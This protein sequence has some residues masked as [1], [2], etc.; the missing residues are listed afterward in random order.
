MCREQNIEAALPLKWRGWG[1]KFAFMRLIAGQVPLKVIFPLRKAALP[2]FIFVGFS[3]LAVNVISR[4]F[5]R[6]FTPVSSRIA[7]ECDSSH[8]M[9]EEKM[10]GSVDRLLRTVI[11]MRGNTTSSVRYIGKRD[12]KSE[13]HLIEHLMGIV[14]RD[15]IR[16]GSTPIIQ[17]S[18]FSGGKCRNFDDRLPITV[19]R[20]PIVPNCRFQN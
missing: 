1:F 17:Y 7:L 20:Q 16:R 2:D 3:F 15:F 5:C 19:V 8:R 12:L 13:H 4:M 11:R 10:S 9:N 6:F 14:S 18:R